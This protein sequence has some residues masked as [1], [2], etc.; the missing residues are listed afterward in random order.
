MAPGVRQTLRLEGRPR[1]CAD[2][3]NVAPR[4]HMSASIEPVPLCRSI[5]T[6]Y[7]LTCDREVGHPGAH[8]GY[9]EEHDEVLFW[10][11]DRR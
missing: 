7:R 5:D 9:L 1:P 4:H 8:R 11:R 10:N 2:A 6:L 3:I